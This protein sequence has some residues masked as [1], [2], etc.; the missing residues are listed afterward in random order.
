MK[1]EF[2]DNKVDGN[3]KEVTE[4]DWM[5]QVFLSHK[6]F[7]PSPDATFPCYRGLRGEGKA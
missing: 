5:I 3:S 7:T 2:K 4:K 6:P 1:R